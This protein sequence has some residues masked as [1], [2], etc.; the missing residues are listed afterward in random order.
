MRIKKLTLTNFSRSAHIESLCIRPDNEQELI[1]YLTQQKPKQILTRGSGLSY[2]DCCLNQQGLLIDTQRFNHLISFDRASGIVVCQG[3]VT[4][5]DLLYLDPEF[6]PPVIPGTLHATLAGGIANDIHGKNNHQAQ[7]IGHHIEWLELLINDRVIYCSRDQYKDLF[8]ATIGGLGLTGI[9]LRVAIRLKKTSH[10]VDVVHESYTDIPSLLTQMSTK[11]LSYDYQVAWL[12]LL[13]RAPRALLSLA[14]HCADFTVQKKKHHKVPKLPFCLINKWNMK[15]FNHYHFNTKKSKERL[16]LEE[17][18]NPLDK[19]KQ[20]NYF[21]GAKG[22]LQFQ[23]VFAPEQAASAFEE[24]LTIMKHHKATPTLSVLK[25]LTHSGEGLL[26]FCS[27][28]FTLAIDF[29]N[30]H[31]AHTAIKEMNQLILKKEGKIYLAKDLFLTPEHYKTMYPEH[32]Q[33]AKI[34][35]QYQ[36]PMYSDLAQRLEIVK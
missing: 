9:I 5:H 30:N 27:P 28:G 7:S 2:S 31:V 1:S 4:F 15:W 10:C 18:N 8:Y 21:Y 36:S 19:I 33:F 14:N 23:A 20:W 13:H 35:K 11:G 17:F 32:L 16:S 26:S 25:L 22:L 29:I 6:M 3:G 12:D 24:L 34:L